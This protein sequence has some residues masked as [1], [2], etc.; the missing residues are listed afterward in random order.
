MI[1]FHF[2]WR[3]DPE[4]QRDRLF[5]LHMGATPRAVESMSMS[6]LSGRV[7]D[8][9]S[10]NGCTG[11]SITAAMQTR[12]RLDGLADA[13][14]E[15]SPQA[16]YW[17]L[18]ALD[19]FADEDGGGYIRS[20]I[21]AARAVGVCREESWPFDVAR[22]NQRPSMTAEIEGVARYHGTYERITES[23]PWCAERVLD[24][25]QNKMPVVFGTQVTNA[26][27]AHRG[28]GT[29]AAPKPL[30]TRVGGH[31]LCALGF[32]RSGERIRIKNSWGLWADRGFAWID[33]DWFAD[34]ETQ[35]IWVFRHA[36][37]A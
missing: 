12:R 8:Q 22:I 33:P 25:L 7:R 6:S 16:L 5:K 3:P 14:E 24:A 2:G 29:I 37:A 34:H 10:S 15:L 13:S 30:E 27:M 17:H 36:E 23:G 18:R 21:R 9:E 1:T 19:G 35:D 31:A 4:D 26:F 11:F 32:D 28:T 20:G